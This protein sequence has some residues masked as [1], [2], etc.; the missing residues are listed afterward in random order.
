MQRLLDGMP[1]QEA[2]QGFYA[3]LGLPAP[4]NLLA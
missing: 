2:M 1:L 4:D 3:E